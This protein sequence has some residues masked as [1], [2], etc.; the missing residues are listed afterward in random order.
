MLV[1]KVK[2]GR[3]PVSHGGFSGLCCDT[4]RSHCTALFALY[5]VIYSVLCSLESIRTNL[6]LVF[7]MLIFYSS[8]IVS[9]AVTRET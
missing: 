4:L 5:G 1:S 9:K 6:F 8:R 7:M 2:C 3:T